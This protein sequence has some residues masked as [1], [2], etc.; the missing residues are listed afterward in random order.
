MDWYVYELAPIDF[1]WQHLK[2]VEETAKE[3]GAASASSRA[4]GFDESGDGV[5]IGVNHFLANWEDARSNVFGA[6]EQLQRPPV[7]FWVPK[8][9]GFTFGFVIKI[10]ANGTTFVVSPVE[11]PHLKSL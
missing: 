4:L 6:T 3:L 8:D 7:V 1:F 2:T 10:H 5:Q 11:L 9:D